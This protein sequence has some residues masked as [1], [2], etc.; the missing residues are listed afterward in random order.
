MELRPLLIVLMLGVEVFRP[1]RELLTNLYHQGMAVLSSA[2]SVFGMTGRAGDDCRGRFG[3]RSTSVGQQVRPE[4]SFDGVSFAYDGGHRPALE[5]CLLRAPA[6]RDA[7]RRRE[8][9]APA[10]RRWC[11]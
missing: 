6:G 7:G 8:P 10:N 4:V 3:C 9:A 2:Q 1:M 11:G 5:G